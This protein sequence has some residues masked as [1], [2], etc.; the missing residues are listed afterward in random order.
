MN[1]TALALCRVEKM[2]V[3]SWL[4]N[5]RKNRLGLVR[6][7]LGNVNKRILNFIMATV[8]DADKSANGTEEFEVK[9]FPQVLNDYLE[10]KIKARY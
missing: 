5:F 6:G 1:D 2:E 3:R 7:E 10:N 8:I 9:T 4:G